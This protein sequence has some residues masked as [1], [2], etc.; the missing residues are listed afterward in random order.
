MPDLADKRYIAALAFSHLKSLWVL[1]RPVIVPLALP[2]E[3]AIVTCSVF[4]HF[5][6]SP[7]SDAQAI[8]RWH[9]T[10]KYFYCICMY[11]IRELS[12]HGWLY[13]NGINVECTFTLGLKTI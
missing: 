1:P 7:G 6:T 12:L 11:S 9:I 3:Q 2:S 5:A 10:N 13:G 8:C 4:N